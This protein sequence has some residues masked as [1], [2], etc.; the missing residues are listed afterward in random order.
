MQILTA[1]RDNETRAPYYQS[2][3][4]FTTIAGVKTLVCDQYRGLSIPKICAQAY[5]NAKVRHMV[6][7]VAAKFSAI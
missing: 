6:A 3:R 1:W 2:G 4:V 7:E 5:L